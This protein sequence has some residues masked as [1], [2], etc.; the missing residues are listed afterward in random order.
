MAWHPQTHRWA[1]SSRGKLFAAAVTPFDASGAVH[2]D[3]CT[4]YFAALL[5]RV[6][7]GWLSRCTPVAAPSYPSGSERRSSGW[8]SDS[9][10]P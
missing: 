2:L 3:A 9:G 5:R 6:P 8:H 7:T 10:L 4:P 1:Q